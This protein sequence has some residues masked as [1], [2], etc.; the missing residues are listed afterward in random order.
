[1][2]RLS[3]AGTQDRFIK[4][5]HPFFYFADTVWHAFSTIPLNE[6]QEYLA[7]R[8]QQGFNVLQI[9]AL[10]V[11]T[12][13]SDTLLGIYPFQI[14][15]DGRWDFF[16]VNEEYFQRA[17]TLVEM[18]TRAGFT[19]ALAPLWQGYVVGTTVSKRFPQYIMPFERIQS[20]IEYIVTLFDKYHPIYIAGGDTQFGTQETIDSYLE[21]LRALKSAAPEALTTLHPGAELDFP[22]QIVASPYLDFYMYQSGHI[23]EEQD[24]PYRLGTIYDQKQPKKPIVNGE[25]CYEGH[26]FGFKYGRF[27]A[28]EVRRAFWNSVL[29]GAK[30]GFTYGAHGIWSW[31][32]Q[33]AAFNNEAWSLM[34]LDWRAALRLPGAEDVSFSTW[35][36][37]QHNLFDL[38]PWQ[39]G[40]VTP[41]Q[42]IRLAASPSR[43]CIVLY[44]P[45]TLAVTVNCDLCSYQSVMI[46]LSTRNIRHPAIVSGPDGSST[47][48]MV[49]ENTDF[50]LIAR[51]NV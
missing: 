45:Y 3:I 26:S 23:I 38:E 37:E 34:P 24:K 35:L 44:M 28:F 47:V 16:R 39:K 36:F 6:W 17:V 12:D 1:M 4:D 42:D 40:L 25:P 48:Q 15:E 14:E 18:A 21:E 43:D 50:L 11:L 9:I 2:S 19:C 49:N 33:G 29:S 30:A 32:R 22:D 13:V 5:S 10:P 7:Y 27:G 46:N 31:H 20:Y 8:R 51:R 41:Q